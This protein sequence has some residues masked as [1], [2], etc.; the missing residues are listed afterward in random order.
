[1]CRIAAIE[2]S[3]ASTAGAKF[4]FFVRQALLPLLIACLYLLGACPHPIY[5]DHKE[6]KSGH[7]FVQLAI[8]LPRLFPFLDYKRKGN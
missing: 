5:L 8:S 7:P 6:E 3:K 4:F 2:V 1:M